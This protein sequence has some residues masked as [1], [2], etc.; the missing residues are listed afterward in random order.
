MAEIQKWTVGAGALGKGGLCG[1]IGNFDGVH[2]G[3]Q[4]LIAHARR[5]AK[6]TGLPL[7]VICFSPHPRQYFQPDHA[8]FLLMDSHTKARLLATQDVDIVIE[9][10]FDAAVQ[11]MPPE[12]FVRDVLHTA[13]DVRHLFAGGDFAFGKGRAGTVEFLQ[14]SGQA[15]GITVESVSLVSSAKRVSSALPPF[16]RPC[17]SLIWH[18]QNPC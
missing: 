17:K 9:I 3:H 10:A 2:K 11:T 4:A 14:E 5:A 1:A 7:A 13:L 18:W 12:T 16:V 15:L 6:S 8:P